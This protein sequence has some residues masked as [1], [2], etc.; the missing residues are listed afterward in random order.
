MLGLKIVNFIYFSFPDL[1]LGVTITNGHMSQSQ[2]H[3]YM[4]Y[5]KI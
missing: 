2:L 5:R 1:G 4:L 3:D